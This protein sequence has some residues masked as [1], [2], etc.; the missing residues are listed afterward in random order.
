MAL[1]GGRAERKIAVVHTVA[2]ERRPDPLRCREAAGKNLGGIITD[3][4]TT[5]GSTLEGNG[6]AAIAGPPHRGQVGSHWVRLTVGV[7]SNRQRD[8]LGP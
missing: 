7:H 4:A 5:A 8:A 2:A 3:C 1:R 6:D